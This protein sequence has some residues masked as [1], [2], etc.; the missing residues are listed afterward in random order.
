MKKSLI[1]HRLNKSCN[2]GGFSLSDDDAHIQFGQQVLI[3]SRIGNS[4]NQTQDLMVMRLLCLPLE[5]Q[6]GLGVKMSIKN[7]LAYNIDK[8]AAVS[9]LLARVLVQWH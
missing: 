7:S 5:Q 1:F 9:T 4:K 2:L 6:P 3:T 8:N